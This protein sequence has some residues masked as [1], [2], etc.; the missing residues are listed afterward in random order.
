MN[1]N[2]LVV[3]GAAVRLR[4]FAKSMIERTNNDKLSVISFVRNERRLICEQLKLAGIL[5]EFVATLMAGYC[6]VGES[7]L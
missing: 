6:F 2:G 7:G 5:D 1:L 3:C 4:S